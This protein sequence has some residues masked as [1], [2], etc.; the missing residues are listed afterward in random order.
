MR[1]SILLTILMTV[2]LPCV[3]VVRQVTIAQLHEILAAQQAENKNDGDRAQQLISLELT[4]QLTQ[5]TLDSITTEFKP[6]S[7]TVLSLKLLADSSAFLEPPAGEI[8]AKAPPDIATQRTML[9]SAINFIGVTL[10]HMPDFLATRLTD[11]YDNTP[12]SVTHSGWAPHT[13]L[14]SAG[15]FSHHITYR[16]GEEVLDRQQ[17][18]S[19]AKPK[20]EPSPMGLTSFGEFGPALR[21]IISDASK[22]ILKWS[23]WEQSA[24]G[25]VA[26]YHYEVP[27]A[28]SHYSVDYCNVK[29]SQLVNV[30]P[31]TIPSG[32]DEDCYHGTPSYHGNL[33]LDPATGVVLRVTIESDLKPSD[34]ITR[35]A[36]SVQYGP[37]EIGDN[38][39]ICPV[40][41]IAISLTKS[42]GKGDMSDREILRI[43]EV[44]FT[45]YHRFGST[46]RIIT[47]VPPSN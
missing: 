41:S 10:H 37:V 42:H 22:G 19:G 4:E 39:Y 29:G 13:D 5:P 1:K 6:G 33:Y 44:S 43:N 3:A 12:L 18:S 8:L 46:S 45:D 20:N 21:F 17:D 2:A 30:G 36:I 24:A 9:K 14:H 32:V 15:T 31:G 26:V 16:N 25:P 11:S 34:P 7:K 47:D 27:A 23:H 28:A 35:A 38:S 40:H